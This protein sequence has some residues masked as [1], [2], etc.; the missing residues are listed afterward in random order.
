MAQLGLDRTME[1][2]YP[3]SLVHLIFLENVFII[4]I[5]NTGSALP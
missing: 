3:H 1:G 4:V 5:N 2:L